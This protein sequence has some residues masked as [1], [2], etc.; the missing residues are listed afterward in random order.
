LDTLLEAIASREPAPA[1][2]SAAAA[3]L[4]T[5]AALVQKVAK[6]SVKK[7]PD[8][9]RVHDRAAELRSTSEEL[10]EHDSVAYL[11]FV[12]A[13]KAGVDVDAARDE[14]IDVPLRIVRS[15]SELAGLARQLA[16]HG[17]PRLR[18]DAVAAE[19]LAA[20]AAETAAFL[21]M[22]NV[23]ATGDPRRIEAQKLAAQTAA[24]KDA[25]LRM[26]WAE[27]QEPAP[28]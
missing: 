25:W 12:A 28:Q 19:I 6:L 14:T 10:V 13:V 21:V 15:A 27:S 23:S 24:Q 9:S 7:W 5:A 22:V 26:L 17:N 18:D 2:G 4:A 16:N 8:A 11:A 20:A 1:S 3:V